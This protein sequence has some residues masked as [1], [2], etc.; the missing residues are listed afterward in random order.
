MTWEMPVMV[1]L[2][3]A[4][5][6]DDVRTPITSNDRIFLV[7]IRLEL[8]TSYPRSRDWSRTSSIEIRRPLLC[9]TEA[10]HSNTVLRKCHL[11]NRAS[12]EHIIHGGRKRDC[13]RTAS[14][15]SQDEDALLCAGAQRHIH[16]CR[17]TWNRRSRSGADRSLQCSTESANYSNNSPAYGLK[18][19]RASWISVPSASRSMDIIHTRCFWI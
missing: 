2:S 15:V 16:I 6:R 4:R 9:S 1:G 14:I 7:R 17:D 10:Q 11:G 12:G 8:V 5:P 18:F 19:Y 13:P 3:C